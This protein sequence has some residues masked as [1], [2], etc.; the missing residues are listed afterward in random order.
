LAITPHDS[1][2]STAGL[3]AIPV[4]ALCMIIAGAR[5]GSTWPLKL[6]F[7]CLAILLSIIDIWLTLAFSVV[8]AGGGIA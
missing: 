4:G 1:V 6:L 7:V 5:L 8:L 3:I 2:W